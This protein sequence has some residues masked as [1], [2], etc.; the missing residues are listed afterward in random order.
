[1][2][3][4][5]QLCVLGADALER[6]AGLPPPLDRRARHVVTEHRR[7]AATVEALRMGNV[8]RAGQLFL[9]SHASQRDD[10]HVSVPEVDCLV[11]LAWE[12][13]DV[14]GARLTG[15]GFGGA[16]VALVRP[17]TGRH[18]AARVTAGYARATGRSASIIVPVTT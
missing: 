14:Y 6:I 4:V 12:D 3:G 13:A 18:V 9:A 11:D 5:A 10:F 2:L 15:G 1:M 7:V 16:V 8:E 17:G